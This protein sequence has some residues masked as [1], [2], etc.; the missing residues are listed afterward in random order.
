MDTPESNTAERDPVTR[1]RSR[2][3]G[4]TLARTVLMAALALAAGLYWL[5]KDSPA[6]AAQLREYGLLSI[7]FVGVPIVLAALVIGLLRVW[8]RFKG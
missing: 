6:V 5:G 4:A 1:R 3:S 2:R 7:A 8:R